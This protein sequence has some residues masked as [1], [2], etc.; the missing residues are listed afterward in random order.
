MR[1]LVLYGSLRSDRKGIKAARWIVG[2]L[3]GRGHD[4]T[5]LDALELHLPLLDRMYKEHPKGQAPA[6]LETIAGHLRSADAFVFVTGEYNH[7]LQPGLKNLI[8]HFLEEWFWRPSAIASYSA[9][10]YAGVRAAVHLRAVLGEIGTV[11]IPSTL[12]IAKVQDAFD[13]AGAPRDAAF[14][15]R[16]GRFFDELEWYARALAEARARGV[17]S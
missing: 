1:I 15:R 11:S 3:E 14:E 8:D 9:G 4:V 12:P 17:P 13:D 7:G 6:V 10:A 16:A 2:A 5:F